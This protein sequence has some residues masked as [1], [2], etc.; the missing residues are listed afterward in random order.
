MFSRVL[1]RC[2]LDFLPSFTS[3]SPELTFEKIWPSCPVEVASCLWRQKGKRCT[4]RESPTFAALA[5]ER[6]GA[7][8]VG[9]DRTKTIRSR[10]GFAK[11][12]RFCPC[13]ALGCAHHPLRNSLRFAMHFSRTHSFRSLRHWSGYKP[14]RLCRATNHLPFTCRWYI[15][16]CTSTV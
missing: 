10:S 8:R 11:F 3:I 13:L 16:T 14:P 2:S 4:L 12:S 6:R 9:M 5:A 15:L 7:F 1:R